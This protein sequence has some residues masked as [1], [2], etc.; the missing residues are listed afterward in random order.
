MLSVV[1]LNVIMPSVVAPRYR[2]VCDKVSLGAIQLNNSALIDCGIL[3]QEKIG[4]KIY[5]ALLFL[6]LKYHSQ[7]LRYC[8]IVT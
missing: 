7:L 6:G 5:L 4:L 8:L 1:M 3:T 2:P